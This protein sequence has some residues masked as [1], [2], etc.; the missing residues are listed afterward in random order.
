MREHFIT[1]WTLKIAV[2]FQ[3]VQNSRHLRRGVAQLRDVTPRRIRSAYNGI[4]WSLVS[5]PCV[6]GICICHYVNEKKSAKILLFINKRRA[7]CTT[8]VLAV[9]SLKMSPKCF[10][11]LDASPYPYFCP[12]CFHSHL[13]FSSITDKSFSCEHNKP[14]QN[15]QRNKQKPCKLCYK[16]IQSNHLKIECTLCNT[17]F[18]SS[19]VN[20]KCPVDNED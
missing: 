6:K 8:P 2:C 15:I 4:G 13:V 20:K 18:L 11:I 1:V 12:P 17:F 16:T 19:K 7:F 10:H 3:L 9:S 5:A 14:Y